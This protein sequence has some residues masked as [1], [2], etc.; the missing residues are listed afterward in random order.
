MRPVGRRIGR[1]QCLPFRP[2]DIGGG[3]GGSG[4]AAFYCLNGSPN[5]TGRM[6]VD[7]RQGTGAFQRSHG[8]HDF[9]F[10]FRFGEIIPAVLDHLRDRIAH[11]RYGQSR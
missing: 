8:N 1:R 5:R 9:R 10:G 4:G 2:F 6:L 11:N 7:A 3:H